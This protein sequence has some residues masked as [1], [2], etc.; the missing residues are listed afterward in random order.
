MAVLHTHIETDTETFTYMKS[1][2]VLWSD[3]FGGYWV[4]TLKQ[5]SLLRDFSEPL[6]G[7]ECPRQGS[8]IQMLSPGVLPANSRQ[9]TIQGRTL[10]PGPPFPPLRF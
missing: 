7:S 6:R 1:E 5:L 3:K 8:R 2:E 9:A 4:S 10:S